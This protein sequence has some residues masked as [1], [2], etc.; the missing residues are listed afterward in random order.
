MNEGSGQQEVLSASTNNELLN[1]LI[2]KT[3]N[4]GAA[5]RDVQEQIRNQHPEAV[6]VGIEQ[7]LGAL[8]GVVVDVGKDVS[9]R[10]VGLEGKMEDI[11][12]AVARI[13]LEVTGPGGRLVGQMSG[14]QGSIEQYVEY[15]RYP[16]KKEV[17]HRHFVGKVVWVIAG[18][19]LIILSMGL[20]WGRTWMQ[21]ERYERNDWLWRGAMLSDDSA[22]VK[23]VDTMAREYDAGAEQFQKDV[24]NE[25]E[26]RADLYRHWWRAQKETQKVIELQGQRKKR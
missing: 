17:H 24:E 3:V 16:A 20:G 1:V 22:V 14:L 26:R 21:A 23:A 7:R 11:G 9:E 5:I 13:G 6:V 10:V 8:E 19:F 18:L 4:N 12:N 15:F 25:E 2:D